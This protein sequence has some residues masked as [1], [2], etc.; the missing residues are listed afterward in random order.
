MT[1]RKPRKPKSLTRVELAAPNV[2]SRVFSKPR[3][4][5]SFKRIV[6]RGKDDLVTHPLKT[7][8]LVAFREPLCEELSELISSGRWYPNASYLC[9]TYKRTGA[10]RELVF[11]TLIDGLVGRCLIDALEP[12]ITEDDDGKTFSGRSHFSN[13]REPGN[14]DDWFKVW[15][16]YTAAIEEAADRGEFTYVY[17]ADIND[18][19]PSIDRTRAIAMLAQRTGAHPS[20]LE[21]LRY[22]LESWLPRFHYSPMAGIP[23]ECNDVSRLVAHNYLKSVDAVFKENPNCVYLRFVDD[24]VVFA[25]NRK[26]A[27]R[28]S[29]QHHLELRQLGLNPSAAKTEIMTVR[30]FQAARQ[31]ETNMKLD[32]AKTNRDVAGLQ[33]IITEWYSQDRDAVEGWDKVTRKIYSLAGQLRADILIDRVMEDIKTKPAVAVPA[34]RY[35]SRFDLGNEQVRDLAHIAQDKNLDLVLSIAIARCCADARFSMECSQPITDMALPQ[36]R[37][38]DDRPGSGYL[39]ALWL[40]VVFKHGDDQQRNDALCDWQSSKDSQWRLHAILV[41]LAEGRLTI[42]EAARAC[43][44]SDS[45]LQLTMRLCGAAQSGL[46]EDAQTHEILKSVIRPINGCYS[47]A[48]RHL[49]LLKI[50]IDSFHHPK[51]LLQWMQSVKERKAGRAVRDVVVMRHVEEWH[52][53]CQTDDRC[54][55]LG[56]RGSPLKPPLQRCP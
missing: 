42:S 27:V 12:A 48:A 45:D 34:L 11:P 4:R 26:A 18:F 35:L 46:L 32:Q 49:P 51:I 47:I 23:V 22:C 50:I 1:K 55:A 28:M 7:P 19:F 6:Q 37:S 44:L 33:N 29:R 39:R 38:T 5:W 24:T 53:R 30:E 36:I 17:D 13:D 14:Y 54:W 56:G 20:L 40:L 2:L 8:I 9:L 25:K 16:D 31:R 52:V 3:L 15:Q 10:F 43:L 21:L 41:A